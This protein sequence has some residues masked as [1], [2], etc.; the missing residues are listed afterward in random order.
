MSITS[1]FL[2]LDP[3]SRIDFVKQLLGYCTHQ[4]QLA[5]MEA[6]CACLCRDFLTLLPSELVFKI[7]CLLDYREVLRHCSM[8]RPRVIKINSINIIKMCYVI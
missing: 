4:E 5:I 7:L 3:A 1:D 8:V 6:L 2:R